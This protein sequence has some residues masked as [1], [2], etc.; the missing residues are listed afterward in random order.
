MAREAR[1]PVRDE[2]PRLEPAGPRRRGR[3]KRQSRAR[4]GI[5]ARREFGNHRTWTPV[6]GWE[7]RLAPPPGFRRIIFARRWRPN[8]P[9]FRRNRRQSTPSPLHQSRLF[10][11]K[12]NAKRADIYVWIQARWNSH[13]QGPGVY[14]GRHRS[15]WPVSRGAPPV[16]GLPPAYSVQPPHS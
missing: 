1:R 15:S 2:E 8:A 5:M 3:A 13:R 16:G 7:N 14:P 9:R 11:L 6:L 12:R 4:A 10:P